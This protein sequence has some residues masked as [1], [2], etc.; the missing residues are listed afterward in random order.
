MA[1][2]VPYVQTVCKFKILC[3]AV[4]LKGLN[5]YSLYSLYIRTSGSV[6]KGSAISLEV[7]GSGPVQLPFFHSLIMHG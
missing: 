6:A 3:D 4:L 2:C 1:A 7:A 5:P